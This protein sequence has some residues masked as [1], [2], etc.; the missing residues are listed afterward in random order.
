L[1]IVLTSIAAQQLTQAS[2]ERRMTQMLQR[3]MMMIADRLTAATQLTT[4]L[5]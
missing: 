3:A 1:E 5:G 4:H 2:T